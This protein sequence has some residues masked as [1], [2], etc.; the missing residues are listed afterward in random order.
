M[1]GWRAKRM[2]HRWERGF[3]ADLARA[4]DSLYGKFTGKFEFTLDE[5][6]SLAGIGKLEP[7]AL[8]ES[9]T[10]FAFSPMRASAMPSTTSSPSRVTAPNRG[11][12]AS[13]MS[14]TSR[15]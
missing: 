9:T 12:G 10:F 5:R 1:L 6:Q 2:T 14:A 8:T 4:F 13:R 11:A 7:A 15:T 3:S